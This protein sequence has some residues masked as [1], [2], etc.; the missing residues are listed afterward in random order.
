LIAVSLAA[1]VIVGCKE[2]GKEAVLVLVMINIAVK[3][4]TG[5]QI[6]IV[7]ETRKKSQLGEKMGI[8][9]RLRMIAEYIIAAEVLMGL[10]LNL[11]IKTTMVE[12][13]LTTMMTTENEVAPEEEEEEEVISAAEAQRG[14]LPFL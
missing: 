8:D 6:T 10:A 1:V 2:E 14:E 12:V 3:I 9:A 4:M 11:V 13:E 5:M 7:L